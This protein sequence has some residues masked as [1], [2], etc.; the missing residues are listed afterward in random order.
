[1]WKTGIDEILDLEKISRGNGPFFSIS[2]WRIEFSFLEMFSNVKILK[3][4][5]SFS[6]R[7][8][9]FGK[10]IL[11]LFSKEWDFA[12]R[13]SFSSR[14][15]PQF[16]FQFSWE[17]IFCSLGWF[18][19]SVFCRKGKYFKKTVLCCWAIFWLQFTKAL[20][21]DY[22]DQESSLGVFWMVAQWKEHM[23]NM[24]EW[25][26]RLTWLESEDQRRRRRDWIFYCI[27]YW[28]Q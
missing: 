25:D 11:F 17:I 22:C 18:W 12:N 24:Q 26:R 16:L 9:R 10:K 5:F 2:S 4:K 28:P 7:N 21:G 20:H 23:Q 6:S 27:W 3:K 15:F 8:S 14:F 19:P 1:M 13:F